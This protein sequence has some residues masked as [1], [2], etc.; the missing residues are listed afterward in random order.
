MKTPKAKYVVTLATRGNPDYNQD[1]TKPLPGI[2]N[3]LAEVTSFEDASHTCVA[4]IS[5]HNLGSGNWA[6]GNVYEGGKHVA[7]V[8]YNGRFITQGD[9]VPQC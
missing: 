8:F 2:A 9:L 1:S 7:K 4:F 6:G 3:T 5:K